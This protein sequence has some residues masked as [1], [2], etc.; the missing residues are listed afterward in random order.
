MN[1]EEASRMLA[2]AALQLKAGIGMMQDFEA[3]C[4]AAA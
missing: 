3:G 2:A 4:A 1:E